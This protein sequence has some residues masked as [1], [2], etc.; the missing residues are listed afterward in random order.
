MLLSGGV[1][2]GRVEVS[3]SSCDHV[4][5]AL[6][7]DFFDAQLVPAVRNCVG[8]PELTG[9]ELLAFVREIMDVLG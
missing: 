1:A 2:I 7:R 5:A 6:D 4:I 8:C 3:E 9:S